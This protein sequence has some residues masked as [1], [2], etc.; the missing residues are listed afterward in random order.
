MRLWV[1]VSFVSGEK[2]LSFPGHRHVTLTDIYLQTS[3]AKV[4]SN[5]A[6]T[7]TDKPLLD[8]N[9]GLH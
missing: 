8:T 4:F 3:G 2:T 5:L 7:P 9:P 6:G 1:E